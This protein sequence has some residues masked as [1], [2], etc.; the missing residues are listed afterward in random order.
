[1]KLVRYLISEFNLRCTGTIR[2]NRIE[3]CPLKNDKQLSQEGRGSYD[4]KVKDGIQI[5]KWQDNKPVHVISTAYGVEPLSTV[6]R[7][8]KKTKSRVDV[9]I[10]HAIKLYN[11]KMGG[12]DLHDMLVELYRSP[13]RARRW[14]MNLFSYMMDLASV[15]SWLLYRRHAKMLGAKCDYSLK[16]FKLAVSTSLRANSEKVCLDAGGRVRAQTIQR[17]RGYRPDDS[18]RYD[19]NHHFPSFRTSQ[20]RCKFCKNGWTT[21]LCVRCDVSLC[22]VP[23][24]QCFTHFHFNKEISED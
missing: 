15:N 12:V 10:P 18:I 14:Y 8:D 19:G 2:K 7:Y 22:F 16:S 13:S 3:D 1:V 5:I 11:K 9:P 6:Q 24:R 17:P 21:V 23:T 20:R 4:A